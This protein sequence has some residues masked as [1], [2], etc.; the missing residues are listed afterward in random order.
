[1]NLSELLAAGAA[2]G[3]GPSWRTAADPTP[4]PTYCPIHPAETPESDGACSTCVTANNADPDESDDDAT[5]VHEDADGRC[6]RLSCYCQFADQLPASDQAG[7]GAAHHQRR[8]LA[9][10]NT[11]TTAELWAVHVQGPDD[12]LAAA[13]R[14]DAEREADRINAAW[15]AYRV[16]FPVIHGISPD[17]HAV[18]IPWDDSPELHVAEVERLARDGYDG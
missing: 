12:V 2:Q 6:W 10:G 9:M 18:V 13:T 14:G 7:A 17:L 4:E 1:M 16:H 3:C 15:E 5:C 11:T 8:E